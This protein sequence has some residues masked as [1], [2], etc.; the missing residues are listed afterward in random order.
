[1]SAFGW[2]YTSESPGQAQGVEGSIQVRGADG[3]TLTGG[4]DLVWDGTTLTVKG[5]ALINNFPISHGNPTLIPADSTFVIPDN[6][7]V[8]LYADDDCTI[9]VA[10]TL[11]IGSGAIVK[12]KDFANC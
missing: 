12:I 9:T 8:C 1:M 4:N 3:A 6:G 5:K 2:I 11:D 7:R 10:G